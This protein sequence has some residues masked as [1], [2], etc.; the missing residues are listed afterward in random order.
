MFRIIQGI[1]D[2]LL[3][4]KKNSI[5]MMRFLTNNDYRDHKEE[6][7]ESEKMDDALSS[8]IVKEKPNVKWSDV[9]GLD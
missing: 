3:A 8:A 6:D 9:A 1:A 5:H 4:R 2:Q 7:K